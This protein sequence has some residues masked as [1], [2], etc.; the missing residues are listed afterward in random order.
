MNLLSSLQRRYCLNGATAM[1]RNPNTRELPR[2]ALAESN[3]DVSRCYPVMHQLR[4]HLDRAAF[5]AQVARQS[6]AGVYRLVYLESGGEVKAV[7]GFRFMECL[8]WGRV[9]YVDD[10]VTLASERSKGFGEQL[11][12][13]LVHRALAEGC[14]QL[15]LDSGVQRFEAHRFY[16]RKRMD[17]TAHHFALKLR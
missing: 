14:D 4:T 6:S 1:T 2:I 12:D 9:M 15:H 17:I 11:F 10:L 3:L 16:L 7:A 8:A 13:W 5:L